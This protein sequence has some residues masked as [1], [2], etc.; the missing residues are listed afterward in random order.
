MS[1][2]NWIDIR[3]LL[4]LAFGQENIESDDQAIRIHFDL[5][6][7]KDL[8]LSILLN[9][10]LSK[11][12]DC[13]YTSEMHQEDGGSS[14]ILL[15]N[16]TK[17]SLVIFKESN[18]KNLLEALAPLEHMS[19]LSD[20]SEVHLHADPKDMNMYNLERLTGTAWHTVIHGPYEEP[21]L[22]AKLEKP[23]TNKARE[24]QEIALAEATI[25]SPH[26]KIKGWV[27]RQERVEE[28]KG[29]APRTAIPTN[30]ATADRERFWENVSRGVY[31]ERVRRKLTEVFTG[32]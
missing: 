1:K 3:D 11:A 9:D 5:S 13:L 25:K 32:R 28:D 14:L 19:V 7:P 23:P 15:P 17:M 10:K 8:Q 12:E 18:P 21:V 22:E 24:L 2:A 20:G 16:N 27:Q 30:M 6:S 31:D 29:I 4:E 26:A